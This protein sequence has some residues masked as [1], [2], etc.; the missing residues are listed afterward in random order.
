M[1]S[2]HDTYMKNVGRVLYRHLKPCAVIST[3]LFLLL[4]SVTG[5]RRS[6][7]DGICPVGPSNGDSTLPET[8]VLLPEY[9]KLDVE[10]NLIF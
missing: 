1:Y 8:S 2:V 9:T 3:Q 5:Y 7:N 10:G 6:G 4:S